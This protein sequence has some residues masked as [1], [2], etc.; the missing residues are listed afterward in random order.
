MR[1]KQREY[2]K[3]LLQVYLNRITS[4]TPEDVAL[5]ELN[6]AINDDRRITWRGSILLKRHRSALTAGKS[7]GV[8]LTKKANPFANLLL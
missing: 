4:F 7:H 6:P 2:R 8:Y 1:E 5:V 3:C